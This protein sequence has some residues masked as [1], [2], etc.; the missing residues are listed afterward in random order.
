MLV[1]TTSE[2]NIFFVPG[3]VVVV[4]VVILGI[5]VVVIPL[6]SGAIFIIYKK[7]IKQF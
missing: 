4:V 1:T 6:L 5:E 2:I 3:V 7:Y